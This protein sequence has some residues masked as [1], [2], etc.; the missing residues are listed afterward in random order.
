MAEHEHA[1]DAPIQ[2]EVDGTRIPIIDKGVTVHQ[3]KG[4]PLSISRHAD[5]TF[6]I[7]DGNTDWIDKIDAFD[8]NGSM[9]R[10][11]VLMKELNAR[12][13]PTGD[14]MC[15][16]DGYV[17]GVGAR[18]ASNSGR[19]RVLGPY[20]LLDSIP[21]T[22]SLK[23]ISNI[24]QLF[25]WFVK[26]FNAGQEL[27]DV[28]LGELETGGQAV[29]EFGG[30]LELAQP[31]IDP[32]FRKFTRNRD[33]LADVAETIIEESVFEIW[34]EPT[35]SGIALRVSLS[36]D[37][38]LDATESGHL[39]LIQNEALYEMRPYNALELKG[40]E[41]QDIEV[42]GTTVSETTF[43]SIVDGDYPVATATYPPLVERAGGELKQV[44][45]SQRAGVQNLE[46]E[47]VSRLKKSLDDIS[48]GTLSTALYPHLRPF[49]TIDAKPAC[50]TVIDTD[51]PTLTY[52]AERVT[53]IYAPD[54]GSVSGPNIPHTEV[55]VSMFIDPTK[56]KAEH[57]TL[58]SKKAQRHLMNQSR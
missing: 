37:E 22:T 55:G 52:E 4:G 39:S 48:G 25:S 31:N 24:E 6:P 51:T 57:T 56:I 30:G 53:H 10:V 58:L 41:G 43:T 12:G 19:L 36:P 14:F 38:T 44:S 28:S 50:A 27:F 47:A 18:G 40:A 21:I 16:I 29:I 5:V 34:F 20:K 32:T 46:E 17:S 3:R 49:H 2:V 35:D 13:E 9:D 7:T 33:T 23:A 54:P 15:P 8:E 45:T 42:G 1:C 11:R 26:E